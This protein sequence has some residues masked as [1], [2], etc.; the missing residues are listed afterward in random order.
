M[1]YE[2]RCLA[3]LATFDLN[4]QLGPTDIQMMACRETTIFRPSAL[5]PKA[6]VGHSPSRECARHKRWGV[7]QSARGNGG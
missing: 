3:R 7:R 6:P 5:E 1:R 4:E 2:M